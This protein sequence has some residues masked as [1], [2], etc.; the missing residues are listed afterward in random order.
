MDLLGMFLMYVF[1]LPITFP[2][3]PSP[4]SSSVYFSPIQTH[5]TQYKHPTNHTQGE[6]T[7]IPNENLAGLEVVVSSTLAWIPDMDGMP[8][9]YSE[10]KTLYPEITLGKMG[11]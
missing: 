11:R 6:G 7:R 5:A 8:V 1:L 4:L 10:E 2:F 9:V 3:L